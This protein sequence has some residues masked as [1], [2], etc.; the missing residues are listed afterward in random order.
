MS[1]FPIPA[2]GEP[3]RILLELSGEE[4]TDNRMA[5]SEWGEMKPKTKWG[6]VPVLHTADGAEM[7]QTKPLV[8]FLGAKLSVGGTIISHTLDT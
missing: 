4:W 7:T 2:L 1:Y 8:R 3:V 6:Q 5:F